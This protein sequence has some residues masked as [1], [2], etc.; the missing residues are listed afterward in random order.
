MKHGYEERLRLL[1][2]QREE[3]KKEVVKVQ[4]ELHQAK[5]EGKGELSAGEK[6]RVQ[7][8]KKKLQET[9]RRLEGKKKECT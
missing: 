4:Q 3:L 2:K 1:H 6:A 7:R 5:G 8:L 9:T